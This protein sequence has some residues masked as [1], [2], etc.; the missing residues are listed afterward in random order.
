M[1][2]LIFSLEV[3]FYLRDIFGLDI[4]IGDYYI[5]YTLLLLFYNFFL[6]LGIERGEEY[7][8]L[9]YLNIVD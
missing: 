4:V 7:L 6:I 5:I 3:E 9:G 2:E 1:L 8:G